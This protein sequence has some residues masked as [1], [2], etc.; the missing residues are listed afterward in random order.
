MNTFTLYQQKVAVVWY[1]YSGRCIPTLYDYFSGSELKQDGVMMIMVLCDKDLFFLIW[2]SFVF[3]AEKRQSSE[4]VRWTTD[5]KTT[6]GV[7]PRNDD[8]P[9][10]NLLFSQNKEQKERT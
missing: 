4:D 2:Y 3:M 5:R 6:I 7:S 10:A 1:S 8:G 9:K